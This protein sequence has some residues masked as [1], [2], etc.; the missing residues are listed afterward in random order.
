VN[1]GGIVIS[2]GYEPRAVSDLGTF[3]SGEWRLKLA[4]ISYRDDRPRPALV[5]AALRSASKVLPEP[6]ITPTRYGVGFVGIHDGR[7]ACFCFV[8]WW[9]EENELHHHTFLAPPEAPAS[10]AETTGTGFIACAWDLAVVSHER[11]AWIDHVLANPR[12]PD[13]DAYLR[14]RL[15]GRI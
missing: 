4:G 13:V 12:G 5:E 3:E 14:Q 15:S 6:A 1:R 2:E 11:Q 10:L 8:D 9:E 7:G